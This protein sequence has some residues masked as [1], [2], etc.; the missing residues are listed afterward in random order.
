ME[1][2]IQLVG[3]L[4]GFLVQTGVT[5]ITITIHVGTRFAEIETRMTE[6]RVHQEHLKDAVDD[7]K[8][9]P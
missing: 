1:W 4:L 5:I 8:K 3:L 7:L 2:K 6:Y 9:K